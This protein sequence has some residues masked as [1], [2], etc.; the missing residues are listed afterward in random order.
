[1]ATATVTHDMIGQ[2]S[3]AADV[4][5]YMLA[6]RAKITIRSKVTQARFTYKIRKLKDGDIWF[7]NLLRGP[8]NDADY[9]YMGIVKKSDTG[10]G[11]IFTRT[12]KSRVT[13]DAVSMKAFRWMFAR[14]AVDLLP[15]NLEVWH[16]G[17]C[18]RCGRSLTVPESIAQGIGP[19]CIKKM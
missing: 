4:Q 5:R 14:V 9:Q 2:L 19:E 8:D 16:E 1:M 6:G 17:T 13:D 10:K 11:L 7:V 18:G 12:A 15:D 3:T